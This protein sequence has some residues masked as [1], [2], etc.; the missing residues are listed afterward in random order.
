MPG[1]N[2]TP[3]INP[4]GELG[5]IPQNTLE[6]IRSQGTGGSVQVQ[7]GGSV[8]TMRFAFAGHFL[9]SIPT[10]L[11]GEGLRS[12][13]SNIHALERQLNSSGMSH[14]ELLDSMPS[15]VP[16]RPPV[17]ASRYP[18]AH[19]QSLLSRIDACS[20]S[21]GSANLTLPQERLICPIT[22]CVPDNGVFV[23]T[24]LQSEVCCLYD[25]TALKELVSRRLPHPISREAI[26][27]AHIVPQEQCHF[28]QERGAF[29]H[30]ASELR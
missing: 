17:A 3:Y 12:A 8:V 6:R 7:L 11:S 9:G 4:R 20:F 10:G 22:L 15:T 30:S 18:A 13:L 16:P 5:A 14:R 27:G 1:I 28:N 24:S 25:S 2:L 23:R 26:T 21:V 19:T 29:I